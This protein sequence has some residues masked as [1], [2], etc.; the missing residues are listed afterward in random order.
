MMP[1]PH[2]MIDLRR[3]MSYHD[4]QYEEACRGD[5]RGMYGG[6]WHDSG[7]VGTVTYAEMRGNVPHYHNL[8]DR[9]YQDHQ[10]AMGLQASRSPTADLEPQ[11]LHLSQAPRASVEPAAQAGPSGSL[12]E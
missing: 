11:Q 8:M 10:H 9:P 6:F 4:T 12:H 5:P 3:G 2:G 7:A 1:L